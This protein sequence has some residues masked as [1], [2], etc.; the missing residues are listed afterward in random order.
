MR[1]TSSWGS[2]T[3]RRP[4]GSWLS[5]ASG[6]R[7][8]A[9]SCTPRRRDCWSSG[10][11]AAESRQR[12]G[13]GKPETFDF[14][15][16][17][18]IC[19]KK[20]NGRFTVVRQTIR[21]RLQ[22]KLSE[23]KAE[24]RRRLH[25]PIPQVGDMAGSGRRWAHPVLRGAHERPGHRLVPVPGGLALAPRAGAAQSHRARLLGADAP[26]RRAVAAPCAH[27]SP[28][29]PEATWRCHLRQEPDAVMPPVRICGGGYG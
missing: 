3:G 14:L 22:A 7:S 17:T 4:S 29:S 12:P 18:H 2:S 21:K 1:T 23:V 6:S 8:S 9:W 27:L 26:A 15:G 20:R 25:D 13:K 11:Y 28:V 19:G 10:P 5:C 24:L 16:F